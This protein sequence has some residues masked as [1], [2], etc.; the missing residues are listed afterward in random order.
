[1][2]LCSGLADL[3]TLLQ[4][5]ENTISAYEL[6]SSGLIQCFLKLFSSTGITSSDPTLSTKQQRKLY[7]KRM[8]VCRTALTDHTTKKL[9]K[10]L[11]SVLET[12]E[13]LPVYQYDQF[14]GGHGLQLLT[15]RFRFR[16][17]RGG[18]GGGGA[19]GGGGSVSGEVTVDESSSGDRHYWFI[20]LCSQL[21]S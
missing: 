12:I 8:A 14:N 6:Y 20:T 3:S 9:V 2:L 15:R 17:E 19:V 10:K 4:E 21:N 13:K 5:D 16:L 18:L 11:I 1:M 7:E